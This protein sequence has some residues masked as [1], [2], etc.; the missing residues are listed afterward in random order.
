MLGRLGWQVLGVAAR[1]HPAA[2]FAIGSVAIA[3]LA[4]YAHL[5]AGDQ[6]FKLDWGAAIL[7]GLGL[8]S[9]AMVTW[10]VATGRK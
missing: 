9:L 6:G 7:A 2:W 1:V 4:H 10:W 5:Y 8:S 3:L